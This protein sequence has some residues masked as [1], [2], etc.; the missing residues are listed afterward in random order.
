MVEGLKQLQQS[1]DEMTAEACQVENIPSKTL[2][3]SDVIEF[4]GG[5]DVWYM[6][7]LWSGDPP[8][9]PVNHGYSEKVKKIKY[10][11][12]QRINQ[13]NDNFLSIS[14]FKDRLTDTWNAILTNDFVFSFK[15]SRAI[16]AYL[17]L[18]KTFSAVKHKLE[19]GI[20]E[21]QRAAIGQIKKCEDAE[22]LS[23]RTQSALNNVN[24]IKAEALT[25][26]LD[27]LKSFYE[28]TEYHQL[29]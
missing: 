9:A 28:T 6:S 14:H 16:K 20:L 22:D 24:K 3:F 15:N 8:M 11:L 19:M 4:R 29:Q 7:D 13:E 26:A 23:K 17:K 1:L 5:N 21:G 10:S 18:E 12:L 2:T 27:T 25:K